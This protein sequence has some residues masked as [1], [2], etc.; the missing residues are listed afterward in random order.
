M[1]LSLVIPL[2][3]IFMM[4]CPPSPSPP[5]SPDASD[6]AAPAPPGP[7]GLD[8]STPKPPGLDSAVPLDQADAICIHLASVDCAQPSTCA[9]TIRRD[10]GIVTD[11]KPDCLL[12]ASS[13]AAVIVCG[14][15]KCTP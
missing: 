4:G 1:K 3:A 12:S 8:G 11:F 5:P 10:Q 14:T 6:S 2:V 13:K 9:A 15:V 7:V